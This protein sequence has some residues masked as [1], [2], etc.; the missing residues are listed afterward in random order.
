M[1]RR[2]KQNEDQPQDT[3]DNIHESSDDTFGL[4]EIEY[5]PLKREEQQPEMESPQPAEPSFTE[6]ETVT[7]EEAEQPVAE[8]ESYREEEYTS[9]F[10]R[11]REEE[12]SIW[13]K[14]AAVIGVLLLAGA[15][16]WYFIYYQPQQKEAAEKARLEQLAKSEEARKLELEKQAQLQREADERR[17]ADSLANAQLKVGAIEVLSERTGRYYVVV[18]SAVDDDLIMDYAE[19]LKGKGV[20]SKIIPPFG[21]HKFYRI[22][23]AEGDTYSDAQATADGLK[24]GEYGDA[25]WV[26]KY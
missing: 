17:R 1:A 7:A 13:P 12:S 25:L 23:V 26:I 18:A 24:G 3:T 19:K 11:E 8:E 2:K 14:V 5:E 21:K 22:S 16:A 6:A 20:S 10:A 15:A 4:P 9:P